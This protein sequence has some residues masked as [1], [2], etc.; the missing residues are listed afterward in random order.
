MNVTENLKGGNRLGDLDM[1][2]RIVLKQ[3]LKMSGV[4][5]WTG[6]T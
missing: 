2:W 5:V 1:V 6:F 4:R 3:I